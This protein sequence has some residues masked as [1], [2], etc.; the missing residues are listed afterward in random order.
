MSGLNAV[1]VRLRLAGSGALINTSTTAT[2]TCDS[3]AAGPV[4]GVFG[5]A[6]L[7]PGTYLVEVD[8]VDV[9]AALVDLLN[10]ISFSVPPGFVMTTPQVYQVV[11]GAFGC[12]VFDA[13]T[14]QPATLNFGMRHEP[15]AI[16]LASLEAV[17]QADGVY[18]LWSTAMEVE[19]LGFF[20][21]RA[22]TPDG[23]GT[24]IHTDLIP[25]QG[26]GEGDAYTFVDETAPDGVL[27]YW[28]EDIDWSFISTF[29]GPVEASVALSAG[30][31]PR[32][33][34]MEWGNPLILWSRG[35]PG[36]AVSPQWSRRMGGGGM[37]WSAVPTSATDVHGDLYRS[38]VPLPEDASAGFLRVLQVFDERGPTP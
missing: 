25:G 24:R 21:H 36:A 14:G 37:E 34:R 27:Y 18:V 5:F 16:T 35:L 9:S 13:V 2:D 8:P 17:R 31:G 30:G 26:T 29:H 20:I 4:P 23:P 11:C 28:L 10:S 38:S 15:T 3:F 1:D 7:A 22:D 19:N 12:E 33:V 32:I 6:D